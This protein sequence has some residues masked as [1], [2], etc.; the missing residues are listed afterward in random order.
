MSAVTVVV[1]SAW[2][3]ASGIE[4]TLACEAET[5]REALRWLL[6]RHPDLEPRLFNV[7]GQVASWVRVFVGDDDIRHLQN[8]DTPLP[9]GGAIVILPAAAGG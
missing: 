9:E 6:D 1:P 7:P 4:G 3:A 8:L 2:R 5:V